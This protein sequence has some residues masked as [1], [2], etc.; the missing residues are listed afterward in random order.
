MPRTPVI[1]ATLACLAL[2][3]LTLPLSGS[4]GAVVASSD[5]EKRDLDQIEF[6]VRKVRQNVASIE[7]RL[8]QPIGVVLKEERRGDPKMVEISSKLDLLYAGLQNIERELRSAAPVPATQSGLARD[9]ASATGKRSSTLV[10]RGEEDASLA[11]EGRVLLHSAICDSG[12][13]L[14]L[15]ANGS[16]VAPVSSLI[17]EQSDSLVRDVTYAGVQQFELGVVVD[18]PLRVRTSEGSPRVTVIYT[19]ID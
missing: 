10:P 5:L 12:K 11:G 2:V 14:L 13:A 19:P 16:I 18:L 17:A 9:I 3:T 8:D 7:R 6:D 15:N 1:V 4:S